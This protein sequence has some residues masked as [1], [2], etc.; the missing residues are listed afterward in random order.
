MNTQDCI[1]LAQIIAA[2]RRGAREYSLGVYLLLAIVS[3]KGEMRSCTIERIIESAGYKNGRPYLGVAHLHNLV[4]Y[5]EKSGRKWWKV[6]PKGESV[7]TRM[8]TRLS[9][10]TAPPAQP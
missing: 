10:H 8:L 4:T 9:I 1:T 3:A 2:I 5:R 6:T 7:L